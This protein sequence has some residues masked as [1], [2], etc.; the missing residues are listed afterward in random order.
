[1]TSEVAFSNATSELNLTNGDASPSQ[2]SIPDY[3]EVESM[4]TRPVILIGIDALHPLRQV[5]F[6]V[7][8]LEQPLTT[9]IHDEFGPRESHNV[10]ESSGL[11]SLDGWGVAASGRW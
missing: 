4:K 1:M 3:T 10:L 5:L 9:S 7:F 8:R 6:C 11:R 2:G